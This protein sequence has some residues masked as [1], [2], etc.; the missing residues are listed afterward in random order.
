LSIT[1]LP[2]AA[3]FERDDGIHQLIRPVSQ[4]VA[5]GEAKFGAIRSRLPGGLGIDPPAVPPIQSLRISDGYSPSLRK[6]F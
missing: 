5:D 3:L 4:N 2:A 6:Y 1:G